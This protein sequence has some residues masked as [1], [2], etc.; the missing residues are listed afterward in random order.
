MFLSVL[1]SPKSPYVVQIWEIFEGNDLTAT[2][3]I[4]TFMKFKGKQCKKIR[5]LS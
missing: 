4:D 5:C 1:T 3:A 2:N